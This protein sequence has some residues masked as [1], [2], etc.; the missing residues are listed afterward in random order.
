MARSGADPV[1]LSHAFDD[2]KEPVLFDFAHTNELGARVV[3]EG[4]FKELRAQLHDLVEG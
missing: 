2:L 3:A 1:D 4:M